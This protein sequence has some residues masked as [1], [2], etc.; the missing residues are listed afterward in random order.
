MKFRFVAV[1][2]AAVALLAGAT[3]VNA[4]TAPSDSDTLAAMCSALDANP[5]FVC[6]PETAPPTTTTTGA[7][8]STTQP[9]TTTTSPTTTPSTTTTST[10][11]TTPAPTTTTTMPM[12]HMVCPGENDN[13]PLGALPPAKPMLC[14][15]LG[16]PVDTHTATANSWVDN[17]DHGASM[18]TLPAA[19]TEGHVGPSGTSKHFLHLNHW[20]VDLRSDS[21]QYPTLLAAWMRPSRTFTPKPDGHVVIEMEV[22]TPIAGTRDAPLLSDSWPELTLSTAAAPTAMNPWGSPFRPNGT[23]LYEAFPQAPTFGCRMQQSRHPICAYYKA[24][25]PG[26]PNYAGGPDR[27]WEINQNGGDVTSEFGG[28]PTTPG[29][30]NVWATCSSTVD[31]DTTCRNLFRFDLTANHIRIDVKRPGGSF[32]RYYEAGL[33]D[34]SLGTI[35]NNPGGFN[36]FF[37][38]FAYRIENNAVL[39]MHWDRLA[40]NL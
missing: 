38:D 6:T 18:A 19:Y 14:D 3:V 23:Y 15:H 32:V 25:T 2:T 31:P 30:A 10:P 11:P 8:T 28:D 4:Q 16:P 34:S 35:L 9:P 5:G 13:T 33:I 26:T 20:M 24:S 12:M 29:L 1:V 22:A 37:G 21:G 17:F 36:V 7:T 39:R 27:L 40:V